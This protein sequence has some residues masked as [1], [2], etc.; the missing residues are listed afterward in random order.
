MPA[1]GRTG[2]SIGGVKVPDS[3]KASLASR[4]SRHARERRRPTAK[5]AIQA[6]YI[7]YPWAPDI[8]MYC[9]SRGEMES[10][11]LFDKARIFG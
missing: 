4:S 2:R 9:A 5:C 10:T 8:V 6:P 1:V 3:P 7:V 11:D